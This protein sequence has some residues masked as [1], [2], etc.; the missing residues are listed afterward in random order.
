[1][2]RVRPG[3]AVPIGAGHEPV[4]MVRN[5]RDPMAMRPTS[6]QFFFFVTIA[7]GKGSG[8]F[9]YGPGA[10]ANGNLV[11]SIAFAQGTD[12][13]GNN[14]N[15][16]INTYNNSTGGVTQL[17]GSEMRMSIGVNLAFDMVPGVA[18]YYS[19]SGGA[20]GQL[21]ESITQ[22]AG[23]DVYGNAFLKGISVYDV[24]NNQAMQL[25]ASALNWYTEPGG[26][27]GAGPWTLFGAILLS[28]AVNA[29]QVTA[30]LRAVAG[31]NAAPT[32]ITTDTWTSLG[33]LAGYTVNIGKYRL[34]TSNQLELDINVT[35][36]AGAAG[37]TSFSVTLPAAYRPVTN[38][39]ALPMGTTKAIAA[40]DIWP[41]LSVT[42]AGAVTVVNNGATTNQ[43]TFNGT[44]SLDN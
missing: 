7:G 34:T 11:A 36:S 41:R 10:P 38:H 43:Y 1:M 31:T 20:L 14:Y 18:L 32:L 28:P 23:T 17:N 37:S 6:Q 21:L 12:P 15:A 33:T 40:A 35:S 25:L 26:A 27:D 4:R 29:L 19:S 13:F 3:C 9:V 2:R 22:G 42:T 24:A 30:P 44:I 39:T 5:G 8:L 16:G